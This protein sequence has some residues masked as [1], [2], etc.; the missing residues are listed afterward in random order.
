[1]E[2]RDGRGATSVRASESRRIAR[3][4]RKGSPRARKFVTAGRE[5]ERDEKGKKKEEGEKKI[6]RRITDC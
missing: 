2:E 1:M 4:R 5:R 3:A 6:A